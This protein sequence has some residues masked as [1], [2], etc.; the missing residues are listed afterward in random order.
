MGNIGQ[1]D[2]L[3]LWDITTWH[4]L[5]EISSAKP[6]PGGG[7]ASVV[8]GAI[9]L[10]LVQMG[11]SISLK[12][13]AKEPAR[14]QRLVNLNVEV[15]EIMSSLK[16]F[17]GRDCRAFEAY[18]ESRSLPSVTEAQ[19]AARDV[20]MQNALVSSTLIPIKSAVEMMRGLKLVE[21]AMELIDSHVISDVYCGALL[22]DASLKGVLLNVDANLGGITNVEVRDIMSGRRLKLGE[23]AKLLFKIVQSKL[24]R[25]RFN[26]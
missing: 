7:A 19:K 20:A 9:G 10:S 14:H 23:A 11:I 21:I 1:P 13:S 12:R 26:S 15:S 22:L 6:V 18:I 8:A 4:L 24:P 25:D 16:L 2:E 5:H 3:M 17:A